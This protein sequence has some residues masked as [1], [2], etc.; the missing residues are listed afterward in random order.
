MNIVKITYNSKPN[1][2]KIGKYSVEIKY[3]ENLDSPEKMV[4][5]FGNFKHKCLENALHKMMYLEYTK[6]TRA[7]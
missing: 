1:K 5:G 2:T 6:I 3:Q 7:I 4:T